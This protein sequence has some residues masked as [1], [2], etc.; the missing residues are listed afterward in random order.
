MFVPKIICE[1]IFIFS[2]KSI[3]YYRPSDSLFSLL[4]NMYLTIKHEQSK[5]KILDAYYLYNKFM[6]NN[7]KSILT[8]PQSI[9][10]QNNKI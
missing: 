10:P 5:E 1:Y 6:K 9:S 3:S 7:K 4:I 8:T 2:L